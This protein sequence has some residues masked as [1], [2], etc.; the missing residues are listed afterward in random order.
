MTAT[1]QLRVMADYGSS[2]IWADGDIGP[3]RHGMVRHADLSLPPEL[4]VAFKRWIEGYW[5]RKQWNQADNDAF[6]RTGRSLAAQLKAH[7][8][9]DVTVTFQPELWQWSRA[10]GTGTVSMAPPG[11]E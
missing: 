11:H 8:G 9:D 5:E 1:A 4:T 7:V 3:F 2:G 6:N 10:R